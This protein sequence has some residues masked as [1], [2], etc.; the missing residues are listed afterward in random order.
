MALLYVSENALHIFLLKVTSSEF[1]VIV[2]QCGMCLKESFSLL[3][4]PQVKL[5]WSVLFALWGGAGHVFCYEQVFV[6][7]SYLV[8][9]KGNWQGWMCFVKYFEINVKAEFADTTLTLSRPTGFGDFCTR[10][11]RLQWLGVSVTLVSK[12]VESYSKA[13]TVQQVF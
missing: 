8:L 1:I 4:Q 9:W 5:L 11:T 10:T 7:G 2:V 3:P 12:V 6:S 13:Q